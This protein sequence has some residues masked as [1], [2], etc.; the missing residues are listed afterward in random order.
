MNVRKKVIRALF[1]TAGTRLA[2]QIM[3]WAIT[4]VV[5]RL[6]TPQDYGL[7]AMATV[8]VGFLV[9]LSEVGLGAALVQ[10]PEVD[11]FT[12]RSIFGAVIVVGVALF[13][14]LVVAAPVIAS[15][16]SETRLTWM[17]RALALQLLI[18][19]FAAIPSA[20]LARTLEF[21]ALSLIHIAGGVCGG[22][23]TLGLA[24][25]GYGVWALVIGN[26]LMQLLR[27]I[28]YQC[29][30]PYLK[31]PVFSLR[32]L[33]GLIRFG[34]QHTAAGVLW[35]MYAQA[36]VLIAGKLLG[37]EVL[38][39]YSV[40]MHLASLPVHKV[41]TTISQVAFP[42]FSR[43]QDDR[44]AV[45]NYVLQGCRLLALVGFPVFFG[46]VSIAPELVHVLLGPQWSTAALPLQLLAIIMPLRLIDNF[47]PT[48]VQGIGRADVSL[49]NLVWA[50]LI[51]P[52]ALIVGANWGLLGI[53]FAWVAVFP[54]LFFINL[55]RSLRVLEIQMRALIREVS[56]P[57][58]MSASMCAVVV[59]AKP[60]IAYRQGEIFVLLILVA[61]GVVTY[62]ALVWFFNREAAREV[63]A[64]L[65]L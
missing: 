54:I 49:K 16:F 3:T 37:K 64:L 7:L 26:L 61:L 13:V 29:V 45:A 14:L 17:I 11:D 10:T 24:F 2:G 5:I 65:K 55:A 58:V 6:L 21:K 23:T 51:M 19:A 62:S 15:F 28:G 53:C 39:Y 33:R 56:F 20:L 1:W 60:L 38:G 4:I 22:L 42:A 48:A 25:A 50:C 47:V 27:T 31:R 41:S 8:F 57:L 40:A 30:V 34:G 52:P 9:L 63:R 18:G 12:L 36:D 43:I 59:T 35:F 32:G 46:M 44:N